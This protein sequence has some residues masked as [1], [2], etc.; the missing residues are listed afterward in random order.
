MTIYIVM[1]CSR[2]YLCFAETEQL[3]CISIILHLFNWI[4]YYIEEKHVC[5]MHLHVYMLYHVRKN[6]KT[7]G[8]YFISTGKG[9]PWKSLFSIISTWLHSIFLYHISLVPHSTFSP[10]DNWIT[11]WTRVFSKP[12]HYS[13]LPTDFKIQYHVS[14]NNIILQFSK[15]YCTSSNGRCMLCYHNLRDS[16]D[17]AFRWMV[18]YYTLRDP[19]HLAMIHD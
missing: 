16:I 9:L 1:F 17:L 4:Q 8:S 5:N 14:E 19:V 10:H 11:G 18:F 15:R 13:M 3:K 12:S 2:L 6:C 7:P